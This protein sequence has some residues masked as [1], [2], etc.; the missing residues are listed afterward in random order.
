MLT[1]ALYWIFHLFLKNIRRL[2]TEKIS[3]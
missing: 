1:I 2:K 3:D